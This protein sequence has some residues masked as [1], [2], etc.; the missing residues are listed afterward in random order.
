L[1]E[2]WRLS[3]QEALERARR[4]G[5]INAVVTV[6]EGA[7]GEAARLE[8]SGVAPRPIGVKDI[9]FTAGLRTTMGSRLFSDYVPTEDA[10]VVTRLRRA[11]YVVIGKTNTHEF[12]SGPRPPPRYLARP[13]TRT[14]LT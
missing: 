4:Q 14:T 5:A 3:V 8:A 10:T 13:G 1:E 12:A 7:E 9:I 2:G 11:G 6:N